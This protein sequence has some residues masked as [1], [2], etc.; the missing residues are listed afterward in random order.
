M[1]IKTILLTLFLLGAIN[2]SHAAISTEGWYYPAIIGGD[3]TTKFL[4][5]VFSTEDVCI[6][7]RTAEYGDGDS[8][9]PW[10]G[11]PGCHYIYA[12]D[13]DNANELYGISYDPAFPIE[14]IGIS[15]EEINI[16]I[17]NIHQLDEEYNI[18]MY[19]R[20]RSLLINESLTRRNK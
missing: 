4:K 3:P 17:N 16:L 2:E 15:F 12:S 10:E 19:K 20:Q 13:I 9:L 14:V 7:V 8:V 18:Q 6:E 1:K 5:G 11:G